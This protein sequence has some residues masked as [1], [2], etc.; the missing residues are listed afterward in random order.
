MNLLCCAVYIFSIFV[1][2]VV[3]VQHGRLAGSV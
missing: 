3:K 1:I 2:N